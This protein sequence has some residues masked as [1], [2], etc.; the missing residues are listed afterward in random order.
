MNEIVSQFITEW[1]TFG[2][3]LLG[4]GYLIYDNWKTNKTRKTNKDETVSIVKSLDGK[5]DNLN[6]RIDII[7][8]KV[9]DF[10]VQVHTRFELMD[11]KIAELPNT[12]ISKMESN[13]ENKKQ[14]HL[15]QMDDLIK[16][17]PK[18]Q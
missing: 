6:D 9:D 14:V 16:L 7:D 17:G 18:L 5:L 10:K 11:D 12:Q 1:G 8:T 2:A 13:V 3:V 15:K 4:I